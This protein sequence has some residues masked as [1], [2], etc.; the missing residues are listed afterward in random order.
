MADF[1]EKVWE[2]AS[3]ASVEAF[4]RHLGCAFF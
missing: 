2:L 4:L 1:V 3:S